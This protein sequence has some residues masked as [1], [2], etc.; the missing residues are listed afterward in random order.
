MF[1]C[2]YISLYDYIFLAQK[3]IPIVDRV[4][5]NV[6]SIITSRQN[7]SF[8]RW[9]NLTQIVHCRRYCPF[10]KKDC[11]IFVCP[12]VASR[13]WA[14]AFQTERRPQ[15]HGSLSEEPR[16]VSNVAVQ[17]F[18]VSRVAGMQWNIW[19]DESAERIIEKNS[20]PA[21]FRLRLLITCVQ[22]RSKRT[23]RQWKY[24]W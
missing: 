6:G 7:A 10:G 9:V 18:E 15:T 5:S 11:T 4:Y 2:Y 21:K 12:T 23:L 1:L 22:G 17:I 14:T 3:Y 24:I 19:F 16:S 8:R 20:R 13:S